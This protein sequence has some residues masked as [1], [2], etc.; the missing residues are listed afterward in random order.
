VLRLPMDLRLLAADNSAA[1]ALAQQTAS[2]ST[3]L[4]LNRLSAAHVAPQRTGLQLLV[5]DNCPVLLQLEPQTRNVF[6][7]RSL[8][9]Q[10]DNVL[11]LP[12]ART[13][14]AVQARAVPASVLHRATVLTALSLKALSA[15]LVLRLQL[16]L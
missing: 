9:R 15:L 2:V 3:P 16:V 10:V 11:R 14:S 8:P 13:L 1:L 12:T 6:T 5:V 7:P 4:R